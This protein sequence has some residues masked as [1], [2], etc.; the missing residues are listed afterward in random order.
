MTAAV[1]VVVVVVVV[2]MQDAVKTGD[3]DEQEV[4]TMR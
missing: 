2:L 1:V 4:G 3:I